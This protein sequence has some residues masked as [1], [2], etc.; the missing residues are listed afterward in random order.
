MQVQ[1]IQNN[2]YN[3]PMF[4]ADI[5]DF[6]NLKIYDYALKCENGSAYMD[7]LLHNLNCLNSKDELEIALI[8]RKFDSAVT[9]TRE[10]AITNT[11]TGKKQTLYD[12]Y[13]C[14]RNELTVCN[15]NHSIHTDNLAEGL[16]K[17]IMMNL[18][19]LFEDISLMPGKQFIE[20]KLKFLMRE[21][22]I[23]ELFAIM[24]NPRHTDTM[25]MSVVKSLGEIVSNAADYSYAMQNRA[26]ASLYKIMKNEHYSEQVRNAAKTCLKNIR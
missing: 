10:Y 21:Q 11:R 20:P 19:E 16:Y 14:A 15:P 23:E 22:E 18:K 9:I 2:S 17:S 6:K 4:K 25:K 3:K 5:K 12:I 13:N 24:Q 7:A 26:E 8:P 1:R